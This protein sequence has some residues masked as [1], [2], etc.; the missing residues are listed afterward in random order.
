MNVNPVLLCFSFLWTLPSFG[1]ATDITEIHFPPRAKELQ[2]S[3][4]SL[5]TAMNYQNVSSLL[6]SVLEVFQIITAY[7]NELVSHE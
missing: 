3:S 2:T 4:P 1:Q 6:T 5:V 7:K